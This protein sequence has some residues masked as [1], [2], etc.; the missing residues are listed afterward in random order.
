MRLTLVA[1]CLYMIFGY[2][3]NAQNNSATSISTPI[4]QTAAKKEKPFTLALDLSIDSNLKD[5]SQ[6]DYS[7]TLALRVI[8]A[9]RISSKAKI[10]ADFTLEQKNYADKS[11]EVTDT[12]IILER[13]AIDLRPDLTVKPNIFGVI[14]TNEPNR[15]DNSFQGGAGL[16]AIFDLKIDSLGE[17]ATLTYAPSFLQNFY[18]FESNNNLEA[19]LS[20]R[21]RHNLAFLQPLGNGFSL[22]LFGRYQTGWTYTNA[23]RTIFILYESLKYDISEN[24]A[25]YLQHTNQA[26]ALRA[27][28][29]D[30]NVRLYDDS[31]STFAIG[32]EASL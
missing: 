29:V 13:D 22:E 24:A 28:G 10:K 32:L 25:V 2:R 9:L 17:Q 1:I 21:I 4:S 30:S 11:S 5:Q 19:N 3:A 12:A 15:N 7:S 26:N 31:T 14:P 18:E 27:N 16:G 23:L 6:S 8:P 20:Y